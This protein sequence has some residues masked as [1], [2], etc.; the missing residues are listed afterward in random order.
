MLNRMIALTFDDPFT[1]EE[2]RIVIHHLG[3]QGLC[4]TDEVAVVTKGYDGSIRLSQDVLVIRG[5]TRTLQLVGV[6]AAAISGAESPILLGANGI[7]VINR[8]NDH[9]TVRRLVAQV[10]EQLRTGTS[11]LILFVRS[12]LERY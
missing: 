11:V 2:A 12:D 4:D 5:D 3:D 1:A 10:G 9:T 6:V 7:D 8:V